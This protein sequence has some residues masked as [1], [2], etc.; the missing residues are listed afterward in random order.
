MTGGVS[1]G[2]GSSLATA[3]PT[4]IP[5]AAEKK[6]GSL[7]VQVSNAAVQVYRAHT[8]RGPTKAKTTIDHNLVV[9][10]LRETLTTGERN[11]VAAGEHDTVAEMRRAYG[12]LVHQPLID[13]VEQLTGR[14]V[15][16]L[17]SDLHVDQDIA[18]EVFVL[19]PESPPLASD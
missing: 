16:A 5:A 11:L 9:V 19:A 2:D 18:I 14:D 15:L 17:L 3:A 7:T 1:I 4:T 13:A 12:R 6:N 10:E 8:G